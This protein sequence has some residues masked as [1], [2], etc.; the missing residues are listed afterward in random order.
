MNA[1][2]FDLILLIGSLVGSVWAWSTK[3]SI[4]GYISAGLFLLAALLNLLAYRKDLDQ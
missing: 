4:L 2:S 3:Q 1:K